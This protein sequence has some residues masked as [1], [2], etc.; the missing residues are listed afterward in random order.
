MGLS[1][2]ILLGCLKRE[3]STDHDAEQKQNL[4]LEKARPHVYKSMLA[5]LSIMSWVLSR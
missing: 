3:F 1:E 5:F 4:G 2:V